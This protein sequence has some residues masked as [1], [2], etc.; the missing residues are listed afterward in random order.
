[1]NETFNPEFESYETEKIL[2][3]FNLSPE[4]EV[5]LKGDIKLFKGL[6]RIFVHPFYEQLERGGSEFREQG[7]NKVRKGIKR[8]INSTHENVPP[9]I[10]MEEETRINDIRQE[11]KPELAHRAYLVPTYEGTSE[12]RLTSI[13]NPLENV[14]ENWSRLINRLN[15]LGV[16]K[17]LIGGM[18]LE[19][20]DKFLEEK[21]GLYGCV[22]DAVNHLKQDFEVQVSNLNFPDSRKEYQ[23][24]QE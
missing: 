24:S 23:E 22:G 10:F 17:V 7:M 18:W 4:Q 16:S 6:V 12:P 2:D 13:D 5:D 3:L 11:L 15:G 21:T 19:I 14:G 20:G 9:L 8:I 1:M